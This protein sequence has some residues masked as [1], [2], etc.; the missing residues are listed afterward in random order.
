[1]AKQFLITRPSH[2]K[3]TSY[4]Y[5]FSKELVKTLKGA[6][7][8]HIESLEL[9]Q[10]NRVNLEN[11]LKTTKPRLVFL[12]GHGDKRTVCGHN[13]EPI[14]D[15]ENIA[16]TKEKII[17]AL[18]CDSLDELGGLA[19]E[20]GAEAFIGYLAKF[21]IVID[22]T[23]EANPRKDR[24]ALPFKRVCV[25]L[26]NSL[27]NGETVE[28]AIRRTKEEYRKLIQSHGT[29]EEDPYGDAPLIRFALQWDLE[30][31]DMKGN[32]TAAF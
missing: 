1:M 9:S 14:L 17:Y 26:I 20:K 23:R 21:M 12:N 18:S 13:R 30:F 19:I 25:T 16:L 24:N 8:I 2:D 3:E 5:E 15:R 11:A 32:S 27:V 22:P 29:S 7:W 10:A 4:L 31:L 28:T 6:K